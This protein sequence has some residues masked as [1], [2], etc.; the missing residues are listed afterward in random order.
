M[1]FL[2]IL[3]NSPELAKV[4]RKKTKADIVASEL[5]GID[6]LEDIVASPTASRLIIR[7][8]RIQAD[9]S[10]AKQARSVLWQ[11]ATCAHSRSLA[12]WLY[13]FCNILSDCNFDNPDH[14]TPW[15]ALSQRDTM[16]ELLHPACIPPDE[17]VSFGYNLSHCSKANAKAL[18]EHWVEVG[19]LEFRKVW[20]NGRLQDP[21]P[22]AERWHMLREDDS[23]AD[24]PDTLVDDA[25][26]HD[27]V[28]GEAALL[29]FKPPK[30][31][32]K[33]P[34]LHLR[35][36]EPAGFLEPI[37]DNDLCLADDIESSPP[38][39]M[40]A[41]DRLHPI[42]TPP[43]V[44]PNTSWCRG[45]YV[46]QNS[47]EV[48]GSEMQS[49][50]NAA[51]AMVKCTVRRCSLDN[52]PVHADAQQLDDNYSIPL[53]A[54]DRSKSMPSPP[55][56]ARWDSDRAWLSS[57]EESE[58]LATFLSRRP[59]TFNVKGVTRFSG[60]SQTWCIVL[61]ALLYAR[62]RAH[63]EVLA[64]GSAPNWARSGQDAAQER[65]SAL[66]YTLPAASLICIMDEL[67]RYLEHISEERRYPGLAP[68]LLYTRFDTQI[69]F[70]RCLLNPYPE[71]VALLKTVLRMVRCHS[72]L[73]HHKF[74]VG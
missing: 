48:R 5:Y 30:F 14:P 67:Q 71:L 59:W 74:N 64:N 46:L 28:T 33:G 32:S 47:R 26:G 40:P 31:G 57:S 8:E 63:K 20:R 50:Q 73:F 51:F 60:Y 15:Q 13:P 24:D 62:G 11:M 72:Y 25:T 56:C 42:W 29:T 49:I 52:A 36:D 17:Q 68:G 58:M 34:L 9:L 4:G 41:Y 23:L 12:D 43:C 38:L 18:I 1:T 70:M 69:E 66:T 3:N 2:A 16:K 39:S 65:A 61:A 55:S 10:N 6:E 44:V 37:H 54:F 19:F 35:L 7:R 53:D 27:E 45:Q 22:V 21:L